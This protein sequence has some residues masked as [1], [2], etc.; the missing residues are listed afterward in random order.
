MNLVRTE[1]MGLLSLALSFRGGE[2]EHSAGNDTF[3]I[4][5][6]TRKRKAAFHESQN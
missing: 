5:M 6:H 2:G 3:M 1:G 4:A